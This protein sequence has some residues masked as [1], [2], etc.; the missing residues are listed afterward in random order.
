M[1]S[2]GIHV[3]NAH[4]FPS[5]LPVFLEGPARISFDQAFDGQSHL[6][7]S[8]IYLW[9]DRSTCSAE[10]GGWDGEEVGSVL[11]EK[12][13]LCQTLLRHALLALQFVFLIK[14]KTEP[15]MNSCCQRVPKSA[16]II[17]ILNNT[18]NHKMYLL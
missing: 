16:L 4:P 12:P 1:V 3:W 6:I 7:T 8:V 2:A 5:Q 10:A 9:V 13:P 17:T 18:N 14:K 15:L 11:G